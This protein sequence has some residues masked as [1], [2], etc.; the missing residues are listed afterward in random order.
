MPTHTLDPWGVVKRS[1]FFFSEITHWVG[2]TRIQPRNCDQYLHFTAAILGKFNILFFSL[3]CSGLSKV[4]MITVVGKIKDML[5]VIFVQK[6]CES[7]LKNNI[8]FLII[9]YFNLKLINIYIFSHS[10]S[11]FDLSETEG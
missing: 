11:Y 7:W 5:G 1:F 9:T 3:E 6:T 2:A 10:L 8:L 4:S